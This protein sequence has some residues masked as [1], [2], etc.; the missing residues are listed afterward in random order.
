MAKL[1]SRKRNALPSSAFALP[2]RRYPVND[3]NHAV[4]AKS[5]ASQMVKAGKLSSAQKAKIV[6]RA[7]RVLGQVGNAME[8]A[9][10]AMRRKRK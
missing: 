1:T 7:N 6:A 10:K 8:A 5:R 4:A 9:S 2:G 3:R